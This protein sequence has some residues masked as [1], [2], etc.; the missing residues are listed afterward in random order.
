MNIGFYACIIFA[1][2]FGIL[3]LIFFLIKEKG[4]SLISGFNSLSKS[5]Q[6]KYDVV[7]MSKDYRNS[8][9]LWTIIMVIGAVLS[10]IFSQYIAI[11]AFLVW[12]VVFCKDVHFDTE[13]A[14]GKYKINTE[15]SSK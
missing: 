1:I 5:E 14:F 10:L 2:I 13:K 15:N 12:L 6:D 4:A 11:L 3:A 7:R 9:V 8:I